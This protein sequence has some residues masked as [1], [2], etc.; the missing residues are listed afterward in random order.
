MKSRFL[1]NGAG[2]I[3][4]LALTVL[5]GFA[6]PA[7]IQKQNSFTVH[8]L[9]SDQPGVADYL[10]PNLV[11]A[12]G[13]VASATSPWWVADNET[14]VATLYNGAGT[15]QSLVV[16]VPGAPTGIVFNGGASFVVMS[17][18]SAGPARFLFASEDGTIS[19]WN[20][21]VPP[22]PPSRQAVVAVDNSAA[23][24]IYKGLAIATTATG[25]FLYAADFHNARVDVFDGAF[26][27]VT[28]AGSFVDPDLPRG[29]APFGIQNLQ[30]HIYVAYAK[31]DE[32]AEDE[33]AGEGLGFVSAFDT[34]GNFVAR[35][36][37]GGP[38]NA[39][40]GMAIAPAGFGRFSG[41]LLVGNFGDGRI[42]A[43]DLATFEPRGHLKTANHHPLVVDGLWGIG[44]GNGAGS[45][46]TTTLY[47]AAGPDDEAHGL[48]GSITSN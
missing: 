35:V 29:F 23:G 18:G 20:P 3:A 9:V 11:N 27:P 39:P 48:F 14:A 13:L 4:L 21:A 7:P 16:A 10:D 47:F 36:A 25:S 1:R 40:W 12:W 26:T 45:G 15:P 24:A 38:L 32:D 43:Y 46:P 5:A 19:G 33:I 41:N 2:P 22:P 31:Q 6:P 30:G 17:G 37:S 28:T 44:F 42:N 8:N 34:S